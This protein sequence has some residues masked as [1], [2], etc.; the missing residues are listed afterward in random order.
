M[1]KIDILFKIIVVGD[2]SV[3]KTQLMNRLLFDQFDINTRPTLGIDFL[4]K[5]LEI[6]NKTIRL[7]MWDTAGQERYKAINQN[8]YSNAHGAAIVFDFTQRES[9]NN[10][11]TWLDNIREY[12]MENSQ[13][14][15][16][17]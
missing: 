17:G 4:K 13:C 12:A 15:L 1:E 10:V 8:F 16:I 3:G 9:F 14:I 7:N 6:G 11:K 5:D 2:P